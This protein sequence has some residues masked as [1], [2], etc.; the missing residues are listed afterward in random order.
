MVSPNGI[1]VQN[2]I[3]VGVGKQLDRLQMLHLFPP[4]VG[5]CRDTTAQV[6][7][8]S[9]DVQGLQAQIDVLVN[10]KAQLQS[11]LDVLLQV[12]GKS[13]SEPT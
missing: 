7:G 5:V 2:A 6:E 9:I 12:V 1:A 13:P 4:L 8:V 11:Q 10:G 3:G